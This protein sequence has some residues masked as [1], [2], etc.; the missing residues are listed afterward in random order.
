M[1]KVG[2]NKSTGLKWQVAFGNKNW[3][4]GIINIFHLINTPLKTIYQSFVWVLP[5]NMIAY[6]GSTSWDSRIFFIFLRLTNFLTRYTSHYLHEFLNQVI[7]I[8]NI[9][10]ECL[11][12]SKVFI[13]YD[14]FQ[15]WNIQWAC[16]EKK[17]NLK[18][19]GKNNENK[20][21]I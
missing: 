3:G 15:L 17:W 8:I 14:V 1:R 13:Y 6:Q 16:L 19:E 21:L 2:F 12:T 11:I 4:E 10:R 5:I 18:Y 9:Y 7:T 20:A